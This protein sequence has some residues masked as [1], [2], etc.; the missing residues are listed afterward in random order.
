M[1]FSTFIWVLFS[2]LSFFFNNKIKLDFVI[3]R[4]NEDLKWVNN[5]PGF[6]RI[7]IYNKGKNDLNYLR[8]GV[9]VKKLE[10]IGR[11]SHTYLTHI[12]ENYSESNS[13]FVNVNNFS[14]AKVSSS[15]STNDNK[16]NWNFYDDL[17]LSDLT[18][19]LPGS[20][21]T[22][23]KKIDYTT[24]ISRSLLKANQTHF[25]STSAINKNFALYFYKSTNKL[26]RVA[27]KETK[28][29][30]L[31]YAMPRPYGEWLKK[32]LPGKKHERVTYHAI[33]AVTKKDILKNRKR[34][35][36]DLLST[37]DKSLNPEAG[38][39]MERSWYSLFTT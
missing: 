35:Y 3:A 38:H 24:I 8:P 31:D 26:N 14:S 36:E 18:V 4:Y 27:N 16:T 21:L 17:N 7:I 20:A 32:Y 12:I 1:L 15:N 10:N 2:T 37:V 9:I 34:V 5:L 29:V 13:K 28:G 30:Q 6:S 22:R 23:H 11:E 33:F 25:P 19:F 39:F